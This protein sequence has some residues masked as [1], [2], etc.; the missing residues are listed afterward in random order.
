MKYNFK[1]R[2]KG[3]TILA[4]LTAFVILVLLVV[5]FSVPNLN[6]KCHPIT[7]NILA[8]LGFIIVLIWWAL[9]A[10]YEEDKENNEERIEQK[11]AK[12][13]RKLARRR[14]TAGIG[15]ESVNMTVIILTA[16][17]AVLT[18][19]GPDKCMNKESTPSTGVQLTFLGSSEN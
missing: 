5:D 11:D 15:N 12:T 2:R 13:M 9:S 1:G 16:L 8:G 3:S 14:W 6:L 17:V 7:T 18:L 19:T 10:E 4:L